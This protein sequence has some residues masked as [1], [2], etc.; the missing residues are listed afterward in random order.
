ME[1]YGG[2][3]LLLVENH[4]GD[5]FKYGLLFSLRCVNMPL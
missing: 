4:T 2:E 3:I 5:L 1:W